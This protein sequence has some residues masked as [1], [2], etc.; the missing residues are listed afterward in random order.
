MLHLFTGFTIGSCVVFQGKVMRVLD[1][2]LTTPFSKSSILKT[3]W[4]RPLHFSL[5]CMNKHGGIEVFGSKV[6]KSVFE[7]D[8]SY[9]EIKHVLSNY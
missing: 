2:V 9:N 5:I 4:F 8:M 7:T 3:S 6:A 1:F